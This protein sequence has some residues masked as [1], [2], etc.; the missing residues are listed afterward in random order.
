MPIEFPELPDNLQRKLS[1]LLEYEPNIALVDDNDSRLWVANLPESLQFVPLDIKVYYAQVESYLRQSFLKS[2]DSE[3]V[4]ID[5]RLRRNT[6]ASLES[7][8]DMHERPLLP[9]LYFSVIY[10]ELI[11]ASGFKDKKKQLTALLALSNQAIELYSD[12]Q[13]VIQ[14]PALASHTLIK[15]IKREFGFESPIDNAI[16][17]HYFAVYHEIGHLVY[18][19]KG[20]CQLRAQLWNACELFSSDRFQQHGQITYWSS[21]SL[22]D[23]NYGIIKTIDRDTDAISEKLRLELC[24]EVFCDW[25]AAVCLMLCPV[26]ENRNPVLL[27]G[28]AIQLNSW[29]QLISDARHELFQLATRKIW[30]SFT[31]DTCAF[32][33]QILLHLVKHS[34]LITGVFEYD[35]LS[36]IGRSI[37]ESDPDDEIAQSVYQATLNRQHVRRLALYCPTSIDIQSDPAALSKH[38]FVNELKNHFITIGAELDANQLKEH[39]DLTSIEKSIT[40]YNFL[41]SYCSEGYLLLHQLRQQLV[42]TLSE[43]TES[44]DDLYQQI[45]AN[46]M[47]ARQSYAISKP[48]DALQILCLEC[49]SSFQREDLDSW[50]TQGDI[51]RGIVQSPNCIHCGSDNTKSP[52]ALVDNSQLVE[53]AKALFLH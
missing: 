35:A 39:V 32:R 19:T 53:D 52:Q 18:K 23:H 24:E 16:S 2:I 31:D 15:S 21:P 44:V 45:S 20:T 47:H 41:C 26:F 8:S 30:P 10:S 33:Q 43:S 27:L 29:N 36:R 25:F 4:V 12:S 40:D 48:S 50:L 6:F 11:L 42:A 22:M 37:S 34:E 51:V 38:A 9:W 7:F 1:E 49:N 5:D 13:N 46:Y 3:F 14:R 17:A 28:S